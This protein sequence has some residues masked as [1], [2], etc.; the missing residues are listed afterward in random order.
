MH[1]AI[2]AGVFG[3]LVFIAVNIL[4]GKKDEQKFSKKSSVDSSGDSDRKQSIRSQQDNRGDIK[5]VKLLRKDL[6]EVKEAINKLKNGDDEN[7]RIIKQVKPDDG[8]NSTGNDISSKSSPSVKKSGEA[9]GVKD[10]K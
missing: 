3:S 4:G 7:G 10:D 2:I 8:G 1:P 9:K 5:H 6:K